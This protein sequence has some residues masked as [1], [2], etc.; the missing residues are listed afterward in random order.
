[1][2]LRSFCAGLA[3][4]GTAAGAGAQQWPAKPIRTI[5]SIMGN[6]D[7]FARIIAQRMGESF[8]QP[9]IVESMPGAGGS[10]AAQTVARAAPDGYTLLLSTASTQV[11]NSL[12]LRNAGYDPV[13]DFTPIAKAAETVQIVI[14]SAAQPF[15]N[16]TELV[17]YARA[18]PGKLSYGTSGVGSA[19]HLS[20][21]QL[22]LLLG[23]D[24][25]HVPYKSG[26]AAVSATATAEIPVNFTILATSA[27][28]VR[29]GKVKILGVNNPGRA[30][31][32][33]VPTISEQIPGYEAPPVWSGYFGPARLP[34]ALVQR[35]QD[36]IV[37]TMSAPDVR[38]KLAE[39]GLATAPAGSEELA[40][41]IKRDLA[42]MGSLLA[43][44][45]IKP[46]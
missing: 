25:V 24:W 27:P 43:K 6:A 31:A 13:K 16:M 12:L 5:M 33:A 22:R 8:G 35:L 2:R 18:N 7:I 37:R 46:E 45:G 23:I 4:L 34:Q 40:A 15:N 32:L 42:S 26:P 11:M 9:V 14:A 41:L 20:A 17:A 29:S 10:I 44:L 1:M 3:L 19:H 39:I 21:E 38:A 30:A 28:F 36:E